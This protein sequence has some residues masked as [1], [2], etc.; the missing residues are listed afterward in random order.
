MVDDDGNN[1]D[2]D[3]VENDDDGNALNESDSSAFIGSSIGFP[4]VSDFVS[5][6]SVMAWE[7]SLARKTV[8]S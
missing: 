2:D 7:W 3:D 5:R 4:M 1:D 6:R 8:A